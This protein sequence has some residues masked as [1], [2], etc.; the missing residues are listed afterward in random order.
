MSIADW[1]SRK[2]PGRE[3]EGLAACLLLFLYVQD[4]RSYDR[5]HEKA[6]RTYRL[7]FTFRQGG[8]VRSQ[9]RVSFA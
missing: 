1:Q 2:I 6:D 4:E 8:R 9:G 5:F 3:I 7:G